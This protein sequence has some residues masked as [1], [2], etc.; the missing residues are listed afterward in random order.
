MRIT[1]SIKFVALMLLTI[2][3]VSCRNSNELYSDKGISFTIP[4][5]FQITDKKIYKNG[6]TNISIKTRSKKDDCFIGVVWIT[7]NLELDN[8]LARFVTELKKEF[9]YHKLD[10]PKFSSIENSQFGKYSSR[11]TIFRSEKDPVGEYHFWAFYVENKTIVIS[12][13]YENRKFSR[14]KDRLELFKNTFKCNK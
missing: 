6:A 14:I 13:V 8:E 3:I 11:H 12:M 4:Q 2:M 5:G 7:G 1:T 10:E 9:D